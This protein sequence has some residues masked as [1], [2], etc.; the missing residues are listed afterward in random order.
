MGPCYLSPDDTDV[1]FLLSVRN[2][3]LVLG[4]VHIGA[5]LTDVP[6]GFVLI[7]C[8]FHLDEGG[9]LVLVGLPPLV[10]GEDTFSVQTSNFGHFISC[11][12]E[13]SNNGLLPTTMELIGQ[14]TKHHCQCKSRKQKK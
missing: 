10:A 11:R 14:F 9:V 8:S 2:G 3:G 12:S 5:S 6:C 4:L 1:R 13:S 7:F